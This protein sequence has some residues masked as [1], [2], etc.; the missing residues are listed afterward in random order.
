M[1]Q[2]KLACIFYRSTIALIRPY[3]TLGRAGDRVELV[4]KVYPGTVLGDAFSTCGKFIF[5]NGPT[6]HF[7]VHFV[8]EMLAFFLDSN[9]DCRLY[10]GI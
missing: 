7:N 4:G 1:S 5:Q 3:S 2:G 8:Q 9:S 10:L 6:T